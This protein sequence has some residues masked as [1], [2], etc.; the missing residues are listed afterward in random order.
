M[1]AKVSESLLW[2]ML[3]KSKSCLVLPTV[4]HKSPRP[5]NLSQLL[6][7]VFFRRDHSSVLLWLS[8]ILSSACSSMFLDTSSEFLIS[9]TV[10]F[11]FRICFWLLLG[12]LDLYWYFH[13]VHASFSL[14]FSTTFFNS[15]SI[16]KTVVLCI[17]C[18]HMVSFRNRFCWH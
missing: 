11:N 7:S 1:G 13:F 8:L 10:L 18:L 17:V 5:M 15:L 6:F 14:T 4:P 12:F 16:F 2:S 9:F 3:P